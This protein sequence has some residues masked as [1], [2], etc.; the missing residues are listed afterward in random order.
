M[1]LYSKVLD[2]WVIHA[3]CTMK[4]EPPTAKHKIHNFFFFF[5][6]PKDGVKAQRGAAETWGT[7]SWGTPQAVWAGPHHP[8]A[9]SRVAGGNPD[10]RPPAGSL[11]LGS[12]EGNPQRLDLDHQG[13][14]AS[15]DRVVAELQPGTEDKPI[16]LPSVVRAGQLGYCQV[17]PQLEES[18]THNLLGCADNS[19]FYPSISSFH[20]RP[21]RC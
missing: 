3:A 10:F 19:H 1:K 15:R 13:P 17:S 8:Q 4:S 7:G 16:A 12:S 21:R 2:V 6:F 20:S 9:G 14:W 18:C 5:F 11:W